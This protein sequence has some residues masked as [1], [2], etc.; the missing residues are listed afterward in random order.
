LPPCFI[1]AKV[2]LLEFNT[3]HLGSDVYVLISKQHS[4]GTDA[5]LLADFSNAKMKDRICDLGTGCGIIP[6]LFFRNKCGKEIT[7]VEI[8]E[9][10]YLQ[11]V[12]SAQISNA[13]EKITFL[14][15]D[16]KDIKSIISAGSMDLVTMNP[17]YKSANTGIISSDSADKIARHE[18]ECTLDD[19]CSCANYLLNFGGRLCL[20]N[21]PE[22]LCDTIS[23]MKNNNIEPKRLRFVTKNA[24]SK[25]WLFLI[26]GKKGSKPF[27][28][29]EKNLIMYKNSSELSDE[30]I[31]IYG[32]YKEGQK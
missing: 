1:Y 25:P 15:H 3:E 8:Q 14:N 23:A 18:T 30:V 6:M 26:E 13:T 16:L 24:D 11:A 17:P 9:K 29:V 22:R 21:R 20:C 5:V 27:L 12:K 32:E 19:I 10:G 4:F 31:K 7:G 28:E 2:I